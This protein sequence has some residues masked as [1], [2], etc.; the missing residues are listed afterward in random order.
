MKSVLEGLNLV[1]QKSNSKQAT[2]AIKEVESLIGE[3]PG[4]YGIKSPLSKARRLFRKEEPDREKALELL[5]ESLEV[6][7]LEIAWRKVAKLNVLPAVREYAES[8]KPTI[9]IR[10]QPRLS[11]ELAKEVSACQADHRDV[12]LYF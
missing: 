10:S 6:L 11:V 5:N 1:I 9:G 2:Q 7:T 3:V 8:L 4:S 12:S